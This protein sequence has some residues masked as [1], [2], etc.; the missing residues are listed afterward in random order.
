MIGFAAPSTKCPL[1]AH[2]GRHRTVF[3]RPPAQARLG[4]DASQNSISLTGFDVIWTLRIEAWTALPSV[5]QPNHSYWP[6]RFAR[7]ARPDI[8]I[9]RLGH[10]LNA[11]PSGTQL[12]AQRSYDRIDNVAADIGSSPDALD[13]ILSSHHCRRTVDR[14]PSHRDLTPIAC[15]IQVVVMGHSMRAGV[16]QSRHLLDHV[17]PGDLEHHRVRHAVSRLF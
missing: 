7:R 15:E 9:S 2:C 16:D 14:A 5:G 12:L 10:R 11:I 17:A 13:K 1:I 6:A 8:A 4:F 3:K